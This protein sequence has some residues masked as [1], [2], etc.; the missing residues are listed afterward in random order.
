MWAG[1]GG[2][3]GARPKSWGCCTPVTRGESPAAAGRAH[4]LARFLREWEE[5]G[6]EQEM[7]QTAG[8][9]GTATGAATGLG[10]KKE[11][12][13]HSHGTKGVTVSQPCRRVRGLL[14]SSHFS[15]PPSD[16]SSST[17]WMPVWGV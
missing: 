16:E 1:A 13:R 8:S 11:G 12:D 14:V 7:E 2:P 6:R 3:A 5:G 4:P 9:R 10:E 17:P 15:L